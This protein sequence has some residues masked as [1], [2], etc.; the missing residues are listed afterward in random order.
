LDYWIDGGTGALID[1]GDGGIERVEA[2]LEIGGLVVEP[3]QD[4]VVLQFDFIAQ[5]EVAGGDAVVDFVQAG[6]ELGAGDVLGFG[7]WTGEEFFGDENE[8]GDEGRRRRP[9]FGGEGT[10]GGDLAEDAHMV[11]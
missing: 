3:G 9:E 1:T 10:K 5:G 7:L 2:A 8:A 4:P 6:V 11:N